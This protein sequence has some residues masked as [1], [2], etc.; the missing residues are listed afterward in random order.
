MCGGVFYFPLSLQKLALLP[1]YHLSCLL[2]YEEIVCWT[3]GYTNILDKYKA[4]SPPHIF[5]SISSLLSVPA[6]NQ[7]GEL[8]GAG[9][10][11]RTQ[12]LRV[13]WRQ[14]IG[15]CSKTH[16]LIHYHWGIYS[17]YI[18]QTG[19]M[20]CFI[21]TIRNMAIYLTLE[22]GLKPIFNANF[23]NINNCL[24][25]RQLLIIYNE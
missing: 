20:F 6:S 12:C 14:L 8:W 3:H 16:P 23:T 24:R 15:I 4:I 25:F 11:R 18:L 2:S 22:H 19:N 10:R 1:K 17:M 21:K 7:N 13:A 5:E 9:Q